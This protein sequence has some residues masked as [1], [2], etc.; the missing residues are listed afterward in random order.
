MPFDS[1]AFFGKSLSMVKP[2]DP[3]TVS[4]R[5]LGRTVSTKRAGQILVS[6]MRIPG[7]NSEEASKFPGGP[8]AY[9]EELHYRNGTKPRP[10][11]PAQPPLDEEVDMA[12]ATG[13]Q[14]ELAKLVAQYAAAFKETPKTFMVGAP[15]KLTTA[16]EGQGYKIKAFIGGEEFEPV[17]AYVGKKH[18]TI[19]VFKPKDPSE[20]ETIEVP[21]KSCRTVFGAQFP[22]YMKE[23]LAD[24][25]E[26]KE[27]LTAQAKRA[28]EIE[29]NAEAMESY[30]EFGSW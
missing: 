27:E 13:E 12:E 18:G 10:R 21:E 4:P 23:V 16:I 17:R 15:Q 1:D 19:I 8:D 28:A 5:P 11:P 2:I 26:A 3:V 30:Q 7:F 14:T 24:V 29:A 20:F 6:D 22:I 25:L 9:R